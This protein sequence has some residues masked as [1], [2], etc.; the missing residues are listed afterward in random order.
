MKVWMV[1]TY[2]T[3]ELKRLKE[4]L[5]NQNLEHYL[6]KIFVKKNNTSLVE[7][8][9]FPGY[10]FIYACKNSFQ[11]IRFTKGI[12]KVISFNKNIAVLEEHEIAELKKIEEESISKPESQKI[13][14]GQ[15]AIMSDGP[16]KG[17]FITIASMPCKDRINILVHI[18]GKKRK[19]NVPLIEV[20]L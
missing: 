16:L 12:K 9:L 19:I 3:N 13:S 6:P 2:K 10:I 5:K 11:K 17:S 20:E 14:V 7:E 18:L 1:A 4:N 15:E 8:L